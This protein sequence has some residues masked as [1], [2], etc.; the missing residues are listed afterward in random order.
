M[1]QDP[2][3]IML[4]QLMRVLIMEAL[5]ALVWVGVAFMGLRVFGK[6]K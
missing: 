6:G 2:T 4:D 3:V 1:G 5:K